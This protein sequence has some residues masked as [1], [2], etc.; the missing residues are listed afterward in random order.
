MITFIID[1]VI[2]CLKDV[3]T[4]EIYDTEVVRLKRKRFLSKFNR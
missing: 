1:E 3:E 2:P 4:G